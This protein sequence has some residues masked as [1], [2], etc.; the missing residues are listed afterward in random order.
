MGIIA[1]SAP[2]LDDVV[3]SGKYA[4][5]SVPRCPRRNVSAIVH[6]RGVPLLS[7]NLPIKSGLASLSFNNS[8][9]L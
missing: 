8:E 1:V 3:C 7:Y 5:Y 4:D 6:N 9:A 2:R